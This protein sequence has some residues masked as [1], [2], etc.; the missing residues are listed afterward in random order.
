MNERTERATDRRAD[1]DDTNLLE[2]SPGKALP[3]TNNI[4]DGYKEGR[5]AGSQRASQAASEQ[6]RLAML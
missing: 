3:T 1:A 4:D 6:A 5:Q 2:L